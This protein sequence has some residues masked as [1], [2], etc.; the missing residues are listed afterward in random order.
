MIRGGLDSWPW[1]SALGKRDREWTE[2]TRGKT[3]LF[4]DPAANDRFRRVKMPSVNAQNI[5]GALTF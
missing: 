4:H 5:I 1:Q 3:E 2:V